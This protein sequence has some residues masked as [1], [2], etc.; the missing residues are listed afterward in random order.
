MCETRCKTLVGSAKVNRGLVESYGKL[1]TDKTSRF[2][3]GRFVRLCTFDTY[4]Q[5]MSQ[6]VICLAVGCC[7]MSTVPKP[8]SLCKTLVKMASRVSVLIDGVDQLVK[9]CFRILF[10]LLGVKNFR[11]NGW[12][13]R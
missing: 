1:S 8:P 2:G 5:K 6:N 10:L 11:S 9:R 7:A 12:E 13:M 3:R 4:N